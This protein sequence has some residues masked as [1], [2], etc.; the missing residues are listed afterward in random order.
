M[1]GDK[2]RGDSVGC[3][4]QV[5][6]GCA[7][8]RVLGRP[9]LGYLYP[10]AT[11]LDKIK[12]HSPAGSWDGHTEV[13]QQLH[14]AQALEEFGRVAKRHPRAEQIH[15]PYSCYLVHD[16]H[17]LHGAVHLDPQGAVRVK[18]V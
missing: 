6:K 16:F 4:L 8:Q 1:F 11:S 13:H 9:R 15:L 3:F 18:L 5:L 12:T 10:S 7:R 17:A 14:D 2:L